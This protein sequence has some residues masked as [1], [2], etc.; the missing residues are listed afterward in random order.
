MANG[1]GWFS[2]TAPPR[3]LARP[4]AALAGM[5]AGLLRRLDKMTHHGG[6]NPLDPL[7]NLDFSGTP[8]PHQRLATCGYLE[9]TPA[10]HWRG[11]E[12]EAAGPLTHRCSAQDAG[13]SGH[14]SHGGMLG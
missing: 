13:A 12:P 10:A 2:G 6:R 4:P 11:V 8:H 5:P 3:L 1:G 14:A 7:A 9:P